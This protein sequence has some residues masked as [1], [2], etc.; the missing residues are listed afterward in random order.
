M[1]IFA[2]AGIPMAMMLTMATE[3]HSL[4]ILEIYCMISQTLTNTQ[5]SAHLTNPSCPDEYV[6][7]PNTIYPPAIML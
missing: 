2:A 6:M 1:N 7:L 5:P 3:S 4:S